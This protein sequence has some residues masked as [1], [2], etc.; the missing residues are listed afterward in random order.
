MKVRYMG[1]FMRARDARIGREVLRGE[2]YEVSE[3]TGKI[4][5][6]SGEYQVVVERPIVP[7]TTVKEEEKDIGG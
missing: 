6:K 1:H 5:L 3:E 7:E 2:V 4:L